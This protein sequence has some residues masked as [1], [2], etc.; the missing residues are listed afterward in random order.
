MREYNLI[1]VNEKTDKKTYL[2]SSPLTH[3][4]AV[5][6]KSKFNARPSVRIQLEEIS[7]ARIKNPTKKPSAAQLA[8]RKL[9]AQRA[10]AGT[11]GG[12]KKAKPAAKRA[13]N[14]VPIKRPTALV[15]SPVCVVESSK[16]GR[17]WMLEGFFLHADKAKTTAERIADKNPSLYVRVR[18]EKPA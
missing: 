18:R 6:M 9:F 15:N 12:K 1:A 3:A 4:E 14:P 13:K 8:A 5:T 11:L 16:N 7:S 10:K 2:N 17:E